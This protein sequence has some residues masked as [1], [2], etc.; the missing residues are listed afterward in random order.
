MEEFHFPFG[1]DVM[2]KH[3]DSYPSADSGLLSFSPVSGVVTTSDL[4]TYVRGMD[5]Q[6]DLC[7]I[8]STASASSSFEK[9]RN[10][11]DALGR[12]I[13][14][15]TLGIDGGVTRRSWKYD[16][17]GN[18]LASDERT[19][20]FA[21]TIM[22]T[23][24]SRSRLLSATTYVNDS[25]CSTE[26]YTY[27]DMGQMI[28]GAHGNGLTES[29]A[30]DIRGWL[31]S[32]SATRN[33]NTLFNSGLGYFTGGVGGQ[34]SYTG[35]IMTL[36][37]RQGPESGKQYKFSY[38][39]LGRL[40]ESAMYI[41]STYADGNSEKGITYD[42]NG[43]ILTLKRYVGSALSDDMS[44]TYSGNHRDGYLYDSMGDVTTV[45]A[46]GPVSSFNRLSLPDSVSEAGGDTTIY[47]Y[48]VDGTKVSAINLE[49]RGYRYRGSL[50]FAADTGTVTFESTDFP[51]GRIVRDGRSYRLLHFTTDHI[52]SV[53]MITDGSGTVEE[54][55]DYLPFG[56]AL[57]AI[58]SVP[59]GSKGDFM[60]SG[61][62][63]QDDERGLLDFGARMYDPSAMI[64]TSMDPF[65]EKYPF[66][67]PY[68]YCGNNPIIYI[69][70]TGM[71]IEDGS[72]KEWERR[73][74]DVTSQRDYL[75]KRVDKLAAK[76]EAKGWSAEKLAS[77]I[78][79]KTERITSL[80]TSLGTMGTLES[81][82]QG[83]ILSHTAPG[84][85]GGVTLNTGTNIIDI[86]FGS[87]STGNFVHEM[88]HAGQFEAGDMAFDS[89]TGMTLAQDIYD[90]VSA[91]KSQFAYDPSSVSGLP[92]TSVANSFGSIT[93]SWMQG[94]AGGTL[95]APGG[96]ANTGVGPLNINSTRADFI[97]AYPSNPA[98]KT[99]PASYILKTSYPNI[100]YKK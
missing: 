92:S 89:K 86:K 6:D 37:W 25:L 7:G 79:D 10:Y 48:L 55:Y 59:C 38:D 99:L 15:V 43:N 57:D 2:R 60:F 46:G 70:P 36:S 27:D 88:I 87:S 14:E 12:L 19:D 1:I 98:I 3:Y 40:T 58:T 13:Q 11:Y 26:T 30:Y 9:R 18:V 8:S 53:R 41:D 39:L 52:G 56:M 22:N 80:N 96:T 71:Y 49:G 47:A 32:H 16:F 72:K 45:P 81:S 95:Y 31:T 84:E 28:S 42:R 93:S 90:E 51:G 94:L 78:G 29:Y 44:Y 61:K 75:Q 62:E 67:S 17:R 20:G 34:S 66:L 91:Y 83:Y 74:S 23:Y 54:R 63:R 97:N 4:R 24:D 5:T 69:D 64:W 77:R 73:K 35:N 33:G 100:Y 76:A 21:K 65:A 85:N 82:S 68:A 50:R